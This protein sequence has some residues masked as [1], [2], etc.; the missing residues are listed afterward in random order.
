MPERKINAKER[1]T[2]IDLTGQTYPLPGMMVDGSALLTID[3]VDAA[4]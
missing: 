4:T 1:A 2:G 3:L